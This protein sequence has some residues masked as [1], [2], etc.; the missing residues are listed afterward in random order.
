M[1]SS[2]T[3]HFSRKAFILSWYFCLMCSVLAGFDFFRKMAKS[4]SMV[5]LTERVGYLSLV[6]P[7]SLSPLVTTAPRACSRKVIEFFSF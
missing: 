6:S 4:L 7:I 3:V 2:G 1:S 5:S